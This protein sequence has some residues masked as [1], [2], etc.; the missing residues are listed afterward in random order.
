MNGVV[1]DTSVWIDFLCGKPAQFLEDA[2]AHSS[3]ILPP[4][5]IAELIS[6]AADERQQ[7]QL[8]EMLSELP[9]HPAGR[10]HWAA[11]GRLRR[12]LAAKGLA[13][14]T[15]DAHVAQCA[16]DLETSLLTRDA[17]FQRIA[18]YVPL[19]VRSE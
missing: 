14:S 10:E 4:I 2:L 5:V 19:Q 12:A 16:L 3:V 17:V 1:V 9:V 8:E 7:T 18:K 13:V 11:V 15:P 6:G